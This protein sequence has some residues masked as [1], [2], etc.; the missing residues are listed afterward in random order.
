MRA[1]FA[2]ALG[3]HLAELHGRHFDVQVDAVQQRA[4]DAAEVALDF[5]RGAL[6]FVGHLAVGR[7]VHRGDE[8]ELG[9]ERHRACGA[10][11]G[12]MAFFERLAQGFQHAALELGQLI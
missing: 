12:D 8:H 9:G 7:R 10:A 2:G 4:G 3:G 6:G 5:A 11:D 1:G